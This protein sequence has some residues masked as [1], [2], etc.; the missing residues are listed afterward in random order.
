M[1]LQWRDCFSDKNDPDRP[2][3]P[4]QKAPGPYK[5]P[6]RED[7][8]E[9]DGNKKVQKEIHFFFYINKFQR[10]NDKNYG[11]KDEKEKDSD[12]EKDVDENYKRL[13]KN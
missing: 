4:P 3:L 1:G 13:E 6:R 11:K 12:S 2:K 7:N 9:Y 8:R 5:K 10:Y